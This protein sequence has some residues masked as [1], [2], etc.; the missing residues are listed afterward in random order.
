[1]PSKPQ[2][3]KPSQ[4]TRSESAGED[5]WPGWEADHTVD[6]GEEHPNGMEVENVTPETGIGKQTEIESEKEGSKNG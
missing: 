3:T 5:G 1:M 4:T 6:S 2:Q